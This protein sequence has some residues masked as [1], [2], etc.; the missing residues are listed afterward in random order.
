MQTDPRTRYTRQIII[1]A[2]WQLLRQK[3]MEKITVKEICALA[4]INRGTY[5][6]H[7]Q[8]CYDLMEQLEAQALDKLEEIL[9]STRD[10]GVQA[11]L[12]SMLQKFQNDEDF[13]AILTRQ[14]PDNAF[15]HRVV[16][17]CFHYMDL[18]LGSGDR[19]ESDDGWR[20][21]Q[22]TFLFAGA[23]GVMAYW[24]HSDRKAPPEQVAAA[25]AALC[26]GAA[27]VEPPAYSL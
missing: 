27:G 4:Q 21:M 19:N 14:S 24:L 9:V 11:V 18:R 6:R 16:G 3:P 5:Y 17:R 22:N 13:L 15:L 8:D 25:I 10:R 20:G 1:S 2:F 26:T 23:S 12:L 7:F